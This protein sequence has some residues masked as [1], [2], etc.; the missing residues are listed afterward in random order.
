MY[1]TA[2][3]QLQRV[4]DVLQ[5]D[6]A[7]VDFASL[8][9]IAQKDVPL[10]DEKA[11][12]W[13]R[14]LTLLAEPLHQLGREVDA[15]E[16]YRASRDMAL[17]T[18]RDMLM[19]LLAAGCVAAQYAACVVLRNSG[20]QTLTEVV[21]K[22][23][24]IVLGSLVIGGMI[25]GMVIMIQGARA[26]LR[27][28]LGDGRKKGETMPPVMRMLFGY[29]STLSSTLVVRYVYARSIGVEAMAELRDALAAGDY[30]GGV[31]W[32]CADAGALNKRNENECSNL[33]F[34]ACEPLDQVMPLEQVLQGAKGSPRYPCPEVLVSMAAALHTIRRDV[35]EGAWDRV[36]LW[37]GV[38]GGIEGLQ[39]LLRPDDADLR[40]QG[41]VSE[42]A[43]QEALGQLASLLAIDKQLR[44][45]PGVLQPGV[46]PLAGMAEQEGDAAASAASCWHTAAVDGSVVAAA[47]TNG[48]CFLARKGE[49]SSALQHVQLP[50]VGAASRSGRTGALLVRDAPDAASVALWVR[51][52]ATAATWQ[53]TKL[54]QATG[55]QQPG[56][57]QQD[58]GVRAAWCGGQPGCEAVSMTPAPDARV[59]ANA[60]SYTRRALKDVDDLLKK[61]GAAKAEGEEWLVRAKLP[62]AAELQAQDGVAGVLRALAPRLVDLAAP[63]ARR[64]G[65]KLQALG[66]A[67]RT[68]LHAALAKHYGP[69]SYY[70][71][72]EAQG[73]D[74]KADDSQIRQAVDYILNGVAALSAQGSEAPRT[75]RRYA[76]L[77]AVQARLAGLPAASLVQLQVGVE[78]LS[79]ACLRH[80]RHF[81]STVGGQSAAS[82][83]GSAVYGF[84]TVS[85]WITFGIYVISAWEA[86][87]R[88][89]D[90]FGNMMQKVV[91]A[92][93]VMTLVTIVMSNLTATARANSQHNSTTQLGNTHALVRA[94]WDLQ[95]AAQKVSAPVS[96]SA[97]ESVRKHAITALEAYERCNAITAGQPQLPFPSAEVVIRA[98]LLLLIVFVIVYV[99]KELEPMKRI[100]NLQLLLDLRAAIKRG[101]ISVLPDAAELLAAA[102]VG[103]QAW[104]ACA[105]VGTVSAAIVA[106]W[107]LATTPNDHAA[108]QT[109][110][111]PFN[112][113]VAA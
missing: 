3:L 74:R 103:E 110:L 46:A 7:D 5:S 37:R 98:V 77:A 94:A 109:A 42:A 82:Q 17:I 53:A 35:S 86:Y 24:A 79:Q 68:R 80:A 62:S 14:V 6:L 88:I 52:P 54:V 9:D 55:A 18:S 12:V 97:A 108:L 57:A 51:G 101:D 32:D 41:P 50:A 60:T 113:C 75:G 95:Q 69:D 111:A 59:Q 61:A 99:M 65:L 39:R 73:A 43:V 4:A 44:Q 96:R 23:G 92:G 45:V 13:A 71:K 22:V 8:A 64:G 83:V 26:Q 56:T 85:L 84:V 81:P 30:T 91:L 67:H 34:D 89:P 38:R 63:I 102:S 100:S 27:N 112:N 2:L 93:V 105:W 20:R 28:V 104:E 47:Y 106:A 40:P 19:V 16:A 76:S 29:A 21:I 15:L 10:D 48:K 90:K 36:S 1:E 33:P 66:G 25:M 107:M 58:L 11:R 49:D 70:R 78:R 87:A 31:A 72:G